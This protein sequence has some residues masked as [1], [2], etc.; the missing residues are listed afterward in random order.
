MSEYR[1]FVLHGKIV[2][3]R[4]YAGDAAMLPEESV[5]TEAVSTWEASGRAYAAYAIDF[6]VLKSGV[7]ALVE[8]NDGFS[9]GSYGLDRAI[10]T[11]FIIARW[12]ELM[13][14]NIA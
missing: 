10:Y 5:I 9:I 13:Q 14:G 6:G 11:D 3:M 4:P 7:T 1:V 2:G 12:Q 8:L